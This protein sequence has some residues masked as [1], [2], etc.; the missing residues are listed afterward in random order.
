MRIN[1]IVA[2]SAGIAMLAFTL[3]ACGILEKQNAKAKAQII[4]GAA[5]T[6]CKLQ[7]AYFVEWGKIGSFEQIKYT[8]P[9]G[10]SFKYGQKIENGVAGWLAE[11]TENLG[12]CPAGSQWIV[13]FKNTC[14]VIL[15]KDK[16]C[17]ELTPAFDKIG[18]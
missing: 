6:W 17:Q 18:G 16:N 12:D 1:H 10:G 14:E 5:G 3:S 2:A 4:P 9:E 15:P 8:A 7:M 11:S 13:L